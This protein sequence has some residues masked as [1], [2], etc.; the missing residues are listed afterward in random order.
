MKIDAKHIAKLAKLEVSEVEESKLEK[1]LSEILNYINR[2]NEVDTNEIQPTSQTTD[3][4]NVTR[5]DDE[6]QPSLS[7]EE[8]LQNTNSKHNGLFKVK[9]VFEE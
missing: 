3:L 9:A 5:N 6:S 4:I 7:Q 1:Q 8:A 2:L